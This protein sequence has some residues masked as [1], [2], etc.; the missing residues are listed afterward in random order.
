MFKDLGHGH[1]DVADNAFGF[2][3]RCYLPKVGYG[4]NSVTYEMQETD[5][6]PASENEL[7]HIFERPIL[8][9]DFKIR[10]KKEKE[11]QQ[12]DIYYVDEYL[13]EIKSYENGGVVFTKW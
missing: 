2:V 11:I 8:P 5:I 1:I 9:N 3:Y 6:L 13:E 4:V 10:R 7:E 12:I